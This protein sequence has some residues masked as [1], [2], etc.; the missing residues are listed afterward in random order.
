MADENVVRLPWLRIVEGA[1]IADDVAELA[2]EF[3][4]WEIGSAWI[5]SASGPDY[6]Y[7]WAKRGDGTL[8]ASPI[9]SILAT[10]L[11]ARALPS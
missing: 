8:I 2:R 3:P 7:L 9:R 4:D 5:A 10:E 6:R 1:V 11:R